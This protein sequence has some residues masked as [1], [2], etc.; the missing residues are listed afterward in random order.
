MLKEKGEKKK[1]I[2]SKIKGKKCIKVCP[3][4]PV[5]VLCSIVT[6]HHINK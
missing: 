3:P 1:E 2:L 5:I 4:Q 6:N